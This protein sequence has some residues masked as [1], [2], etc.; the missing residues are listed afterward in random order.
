MAHSD[1][2]IV[3]LS[4]E[5]ILI[6]V[7]RLMAINAPPEHAGLRLALSSLLARHELILSVMGSSGLKD[8]YLEFDPSS[9]TLDV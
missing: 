6:G 4:K 5:G 9:I 1:Y 8:L 2:Q 7:T 3:A